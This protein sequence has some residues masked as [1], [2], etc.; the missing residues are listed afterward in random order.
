MEHSIH[1]SMKL[2]PKLGNTDP[3]AFRAGA[4]PIGR[5]GLLAPVLGVREQGPGLQAPC[6]ELPHDAGLGL[7][8]VHPLALV[9]FVQQK[10]KKVRIRIWSRLLHMDKLRSKYTYSQEQQP[11]QLP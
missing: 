7:S 11:P 3:S 2:D 9:A 6:P 8:Q 10:G 1:A 4:A 5:Q